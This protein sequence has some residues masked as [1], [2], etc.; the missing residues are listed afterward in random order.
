MLGKLECWI[1]SNGT[2]TCKYSEYSIF[3]LFISQEIFIYS[4]EVVPALVKL[5][6]ESIGQQPAFSRSAL[7]ALAG[8]FCKAPTRAWVCRASSKC[9]EPP[10]HGQISCRTRLWREAQLQ[11][12]WVHQGTPF[13]LAECAQW[14]R[15]WVLGQGQAASPPTHSLSNNT[16]KVGVHQTQQVL[17]YICTHTHKYVIILYITMHCILYSYI[18]YN[19]SNQ[20]ISGWYQRPTTGIDTPLNHVLGQVFIQK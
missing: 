12:C 9:S 5:Q 19:I 1:V 7:C 6:C 10:G 3:S 11:L 8:D 17:I 20:D 13:L 2:E 14:G 16:C 15:S 18:F 4:T